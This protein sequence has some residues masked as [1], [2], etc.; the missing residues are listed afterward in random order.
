VNFIAL[1]APALSALLLAAHFLRAGHAAGVAVS[2]ALL[3]VLAIP[4]RWAARAAQAALLLGGAEW[5]RTLAELVA[6][7]REAHAP[8]ARLAVILAAVAVGTIASALVFESRRLRE[9]YRM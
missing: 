1:L 9:R 2:L 3:A 8:Y 4:H 5:I 6:E 7:R